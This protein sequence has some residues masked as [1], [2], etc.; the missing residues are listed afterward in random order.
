MEPSPAKRLRRE[1]E[2]QSA[3]NSSSEDYSELDS[4]SDLDS[5]VRFAR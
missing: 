4:D 3:D 1:N 5:T 2:E